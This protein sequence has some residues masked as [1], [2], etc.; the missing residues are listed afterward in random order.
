MCDILDR[1]EETN[2]RK[3]CW[4]HANPHSDLSYT[5]PYVSEQGGPQSLLIVKG[6]VHK[7][8][9]AMIISDDEEEEKKNIEDDEFDFDDVHPATGGAKNPNA[10]KRG[11]PTGSINGRKAISK[12]KKT[13]EEVLED[14]QRE[15]LEIARENIALKRAR[16]AAEEKR[17]IE[18]EKR[19]EKKDELRQKKNDNKTQVKLAKLAM[20]KAK[21]ELKLAKLRSQ[22]ILEAGQQS[23]GT[24]TM[25]QHMRETSVVEKPSGAA[26]EA[27]E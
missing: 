26:A 17:N 5:P 12:K 25:E 6:K 27:E 16:V 24:E 3:G 1:Y 14:M 21:V 15:E 7:G 10:L 2:S 18:A 4:L 23:E 19:R 8:P 11:K 9:E 20:R 22:N 13:V